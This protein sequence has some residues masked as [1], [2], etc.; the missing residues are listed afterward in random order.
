MT[1]HIYLH[2]GHGKAGSSAIQS[3]LANS[4]TDLHSFGLVYPEWEPGFIDEAKRYKVSSGNIPRGASLKDFHLRVLDTLG[5][6]RQ[7]F[8]SEM[9]FW[10]LLAGEMFDEMAELM[11]Q[12]VAIT[13]LFLIRDPFPHMVSG[14]KQAVQSGT[15]EGSLD[16][17][18]VR[19]T[20]PE[21]VFRVV[22]QLQEIG[23]DPIVRNYSRCRDELPIVL[24]QWL[25]VPSS[26]FDR[27]LSE[28]VNRS[29]TRSEVE[30]LLLL[31]RYLDS[32][33]SAALANALVN[34]HPHITTGKIQWSEQSIRSF[35]E[36]ITPQVMKT[37]L[38]LPPTERYILPSLEEAVRDFRSDDGGDLQFSPDQLQ[39]VIRE[40]AAGIKQH[41]TRDDTP[42]AVSDLLAGELSRL[43]HIEQ[44]LRLLE[45][46]RTFR[47]TKSARTFYAGVRSR[48]LSD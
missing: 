33:Q 17:F 25:G 37:N 16:E 14:Y 7:V 8:S 40:L 26:I 38:L 30:L 35:H 9:L 47:W 43:R 3:A 12:D 22:T 41:G 19:Y 27:H 39:T 11:D 20:R 2:I 34:E 18:S 31:H 28:E 10:S 36:R 21:H 42:A 1:R 48:I 29:L 6:E 24:G 4:V 23:I 13:I 32:G 5:G 44:S 45:S 15:A 46:S